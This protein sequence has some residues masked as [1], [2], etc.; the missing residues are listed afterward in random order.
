[1]V[2]ITIGVAFRD[3]KG[4]FHGSDGNEVVV[5]DDL[6]TL[7]G[8][9]DAWIVS[10]TP[11]EM[12]AMGLE[13][14]ALF[15]SNDF[16]RTKI[17]TIRQE[18]AGENLTLGAQVS[19]R[20][21]SRIMRLAYEVAEIDT[22]HP[23]TLR[24][25]LRERILPIDI[26]WSNTPVVLEAIDSATQEFARI[27]PT[28]E[29]QH[30][31]TLIAPRIAHAKNIT[32]LVVPSPVRASAKVIKPPFPKKKEAISAWIE[33]NA[34]PMLIR[35]NFSFTVRSPEDA[36]YEIKNIAPTRYRRKG[37]MG[38]VRRASRRW[39][40]HLDALFLL[41]ALD[42]I[43][44]E[45][46]ILFEEA[47]YLGDHP[48]VARFLAQLG[49]EEDA[50]LSCAIFAENLWSALASGNA[51]PIKKDVCANPMTPF[52]R[53]HERILMARVAKDLI[54]A[55]FHVVG[56]GTGKILITENDPARL[57]QAALFSRL[58]PY[59]GKLSFDSP[60]FNP[61]DTIH[62][63][64]STRLSLLVEEMDSLDQEIHGMIIEKIKKIGG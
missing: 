49:E 8:E 37:V 9:L 23:L 63:L 31:F 1:M 51:P 2:N 48:V 52:I 33:S 40:T 55:G 19:A 4:R 7:S 47:T 57:V 64:I 39:F 26:D 29:K 45:E 18:I 41:E 16:F 15:R 42:E 28:P 50:S 21:A 22:V 46:A 3:T 36:I 20:I 13:S 30:V 38:E 14:H 61:N 56:Y 6:K 25:A 5:T 53:A 35:G 27:A 60:L 59:A 24:H 10:L 17:E 11:R 34:C 12:M 54:K 43:H 44:I 58:L 62:A 32:N